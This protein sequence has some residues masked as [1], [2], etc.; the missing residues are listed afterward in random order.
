[1]TKPIEKPTLE[2]KF[3]KFNFNNPDVYFRLREM[4]MKLKQRGHKQYGIAA[5]FE[6]MRFHQALETT[7]PDFKLN[8]NYRALYAR[9]LMKQEPELDGFFKTRRRR[10][11]NE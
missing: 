2:N 8:H 10:G 6:A 5:L 11:E 9:Q 4:A 1:M 3:H 7:D